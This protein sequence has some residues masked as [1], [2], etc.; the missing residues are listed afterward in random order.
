MSENFHAGA[1]ETDRS[2]KRKIDILESMK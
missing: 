1:E 2:G